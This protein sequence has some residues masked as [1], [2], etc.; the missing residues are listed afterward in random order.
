MAK[1]K[2]LGNVVAA[3][4]DKSFELVDAAEGVATA[5]E[6]GDTDLEAELRCGLRKVGGD[7]AYLVRTY[8]RALGVASSG[9]LSKIS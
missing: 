8:Q 1:T 2:P 6:V 7:L 3:I 5:K 4:L 9:P